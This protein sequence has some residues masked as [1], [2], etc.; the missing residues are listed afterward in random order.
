MKEVPC[1]RC[2]S[3]SLLHY[4][5]AYVLRRPVV[6]DEGQLELADERTNEY[7]DN[8]FDCEDCGY[9]PTENELLLSASG[10]ST[11]DPG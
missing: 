10:E 7:D 9:R 5:D 4:T 3:D 8:F 11:S 6:N 1:P 2:G